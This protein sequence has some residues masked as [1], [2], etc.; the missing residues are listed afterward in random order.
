MPIFANGV[1]HDWANAMS[2]W[3]LPEPLPHCSPLSL[4]SGLPFGRISGCGESTTVLVFLVESWV[5]QAELV[6]IL[7][8]E[9]GGI[10]VCDALLTS[11]LGLFWVSSV[12]VL[13]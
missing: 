8:V 7:N 9:P 6:T 1:L 5:Y 3:V 2:T 12:N 13:L 10:V 11:G 4:L